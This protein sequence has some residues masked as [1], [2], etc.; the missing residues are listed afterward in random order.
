MSW[1]A[2]PIAAVTHPDPYPYYATLARRPLE[3]H[4]DIGM[5]VAAGAAD[6]QAVL[7]SDLC[8]VRPRAEPV[9][10][11]IEGTAAG[12]VFGRLVRMTDGPAHAVARRIVVAA[13]AAPDPS[14]VTA[15]ARGLAR[16]QADALELRRHPQ[17]AMQVAF[18]VPA[19][20]MA[21]LLGLTG[22]ALDEAVG[23]TGDFVRG[24]AAGAAADRRDAGALA[25]ARLERTLAALPRGAG[26]LE[27]LAS[28]A[29]QAGGP[30]R[31]NVVA[32]AIG[33]LS[34]PYEATAGLIGNALVA[35]S[36]EPGLRERVRT[37]PA[38][39]PDLVGEVLRHD[40]PVQNTR[41][42]VDRGGVVAGVAV[43]EGDAILVVLAAAN[44]DPAL[45]AEPDAFRLDRPDRRLL[46]FGSGP[47]A[48]PGDRL[49]AAIACG[50]VEAL[51]E[52]DVPLEGLG[53]ARRYLPLVNVRIPVFAA[54]GAADQ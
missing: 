53:D 9:P 40:P 51:L 38:R 19:R 48:C 15:I 7:G 50:A 30:D 25:A 3:R 34:Q 22:P 46:T 35:L 42:F 13:L 16:T 10:R 52:A 23:W 20:V 5:W 27:R 49:A 54:E 11:A 45:H 36:R 28:A 4:P 37:E 31:P 39:L 14:G 44:R 6:V 47:H 12:S 41:R 21:G 18:D 32:N 26:L 33:F 1:P 24:I 17:R 2:D 29:D 8:R 43:Q